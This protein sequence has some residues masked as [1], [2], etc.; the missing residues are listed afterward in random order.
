[1]PSKVTKPYT[2]AQPKLMSIGIDIGKDVFH[3]VGFDHNGKVVL[4]G[5]F[6]GL[7]WMPCSRSCRAASSAWKL[8]SVPTS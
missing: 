6:G 7:N 5:S 4:A 8:V 2:S 3:I 1:M